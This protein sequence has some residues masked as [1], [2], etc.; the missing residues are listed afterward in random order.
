M[1]PIRSFQICL[2]LL[3]LVVFPG[4]APEPEAENAPIPQHAHAAIIPAPTSVV[5]RDDAWSFNS[6][7]RVLHS[8]DAS[9]QG[10]N[11][12]HFFADLIQRTLGINARLDQSVEH[13][14]GSIQF[15]LDPATSSAG[16]AYTVTITPA[17]VRVR[18]GSNGGLLYGAVSVW[19]V[20]SAYR[21]GSI[22]AMTIEDAPRFGWRG[23]MIDSARHYRTL[24]EMK[25]V[26]DVM[27]LHKLNVLHW[28]LTDD[29]AWRLEI[30]KYPKLTEIGAW[31]VPAGAGPAGD[32]DSSTGK[33][34]LYGGFY[35]QEQARELVAYARDRNIIVI[36][37]I[38]MPGHAS[39]AIA[40]YPHLGVTD[41]A[42]A[43]PVVPAD[44]GIYESLFNVEESTF[45]FLED[46]L[47]ETMAIFPSEYIHVGGDEAVKKQ[48]ERSTRVQ[49]RMK[50]LGVE[51]EHALQSYFIRRMEKFLNRHGR[52]LIG[53]DEILEGGLA[54]N[55]TVMSWRGIDGA[56]AAASAGHDAV[57][58]PWPILYFD[59][60]P[61][62][63]GSPPGRGRVVSVEDVYRFDPI[64]DALNEAQRKHI[65]GVQANMWT[66][67]IRTFDRLQY[68]MLPRLAALAEVAWSD[69]QH[70]DWD[71]FSG[72][73]PYQLTRY[74]DL[75]LRFADASAVQ[76]PQGKRRM[77]HE[78]KHCSDKLPLALE[79]DAPVQ[80]DRAVFFVD[81][82]QPCWIYED[83]QL[84]GRT[85]LQASV[86][87]VPFNFQIGD[88]VNEIKFRPPAT[89]AG[90]LEV[91]IDSCEGE[92][93]ATI[94][95]GA[96]AKNP[97]VSILAPVSLNDQGVR[98]LCF[99]FTQRGVDPTWVIDS[100]ELIEP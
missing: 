63:T 46:V 6:A 2:S 97:E 94:P 50:T 96:A 84:S 57:L 30:K 36:P 8:G 53:W 91:R 51:D 93:V 23:L 77:S 49:A 22:P 95:L 73:L 71:N 32:I 65:L 44:W 98:D 28:H 19:Q 45:G 7:V 42:T 88:A 27:A 39:A 61:L 13:V 92:R 75:K 14:P 80:G 78:L 12:A 9:A 86:G 60:R 48:W 43:N 52:R 69:A 35:T 38:E 40:A 62:D 21:G 81:I 89:E 76:Q 59:N 100:V 20:M 79:D 16:D 26:V 37:E 82:M 47:A 31:R 25:A 11:V 54:P 10:S 66:E 74:K 83:A 70:I 68:M 41:V 1:V 17:G 15:A 18:A 99:T 85:N 64:P 55:A 5:F 72:R 29:Q 24:D 4:C 33:P 87:Q 58:T 3:C 34:R 67:H 90:E 56:I